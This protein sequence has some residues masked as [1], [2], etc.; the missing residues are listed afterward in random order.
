MDCCSKFLKQNILQTVAVLKAVQKKYK[1]PW[2]LFFSLL[3]LLEP[4]KLLSMEPYIGAS[5]TAL[6]FQGPSRSRQ[7]PGSFFH[8]TLITTTSIFPGLLG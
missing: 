4:L 2:P 1:S 3:V 5:Y 8:Q 6:D 7:L